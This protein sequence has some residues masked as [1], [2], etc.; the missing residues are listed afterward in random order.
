MTEHVPKNPFPAQHWS[1]QSPIELR[2][3]HSLHVPSLRTQP[4]EHDYREAPYAGSFA[5][6]PGH[7]NFVLTKPYPGAH[8][9]VVRAAGVTA[10]LVK[11]HVHT[12]PEHDLEGSN[13]GGEI[14]LI[15]EIVAPTQGS[16]L[17]VLGVFFRERA[18]GDPE[19]PEDSA[20]RRFIEGWSGG[21]TGEAGV[22]IDPRCLLPANTSRWFRYEGSLTSAPYDESVSWLVFNEPLRLHS[23]DLEELRRHA[24]QPER[25]PQAL[26]RRFVLR[27]FE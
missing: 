25:K 23:R 15:H 9:P 19:Q 12:P 16:T 10:Q 2:A 20:L 8:P 5:G 21:C 24:E 11:I 14:H 18:E 7:R 4:F 17:L 3:S 13:E 27:S 1:Q 26:N 6:E 22:T